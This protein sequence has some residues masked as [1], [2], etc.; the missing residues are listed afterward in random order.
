MIEDHAMLLIYLM[1]GVPTVVGL[2]VAFLTR[3]RRYYYKI[4]GGRLWKIYDH[5]RGRKEKG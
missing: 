4:S 1:I 5:P 3:P 2:L